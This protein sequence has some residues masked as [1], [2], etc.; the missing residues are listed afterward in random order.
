MYAKAVLHEDEE[1]FVE[2]LISTPPNTLAPFV[3]PFA[4]LTLPSAATCSCNFSRQLKWLLFFKE[5]NLLDPSWPREQPA[6]ALWV[7]FQALTGLHNAGLT[8]GD[9]RLGN[10]FFIQANGGILAKFCDM[11]RGGELESWSTSWHFGDSPM[12]EGLLCGG[13]RKFDYRQFALLVISLVDNDSSAYNMSKE[14][15]NTWI[16]EKNVCSVVAALFSGKD[17]K[18]CGSLCGD[19]RG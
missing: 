11:D 14:Q 17:G 1:V 2:G 19:E 9:I 12:Y 16:K 4:A 5:Q 18:G 10:I 3:Q 8:H 7:T 15:V 6:F 13:R